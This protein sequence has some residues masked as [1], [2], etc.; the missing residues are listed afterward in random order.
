[1]KR[2][3]REHGARFHCDVRANQRRLSDGSIPWIRFSGKISA[4]YRQQSERMNIPLATVC[5][6]VLQVQGFNSNISHGVTPIASSNF[7]G[8]HSSHSLQSTATPAQLMVP[9]YPANEVMQAA[10]IRCENTEKHFQEKANATRKKRLQMQRLTQFWIIRNT[11]SQAIRSAR[12]LLAFAPM[13]MARDAHHI[14][15]QSSENSGT[16][17][18]HI[19]NATASNTKIALCFAR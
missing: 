6:L 5:T 4:E 11:S 12:V 3:G 13:A 17:G 18:T 14:P 8:K 16:H 10:S 7:D 1:M 9:C 2:K 19:A 15:A